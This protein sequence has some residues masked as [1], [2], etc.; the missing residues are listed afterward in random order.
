MN[1]LVTGAT[2]LL[3]D[4]LVDILSIEHKVY[5]LSRENI[6]K[7][8]VETILCDLIDFSLEKLPTEID[9]VF[10][11]AQ[12]RHFREFPQKSIDIFKI[13]IEAPLKIANWAIEND[14]KKFFYISSGGIYKNQL[15]TIDE[16]FNINANEKNGF[17]LDSKLSADLLLRN[18]H[19]FFESFAIIRP[20]FIYGPKQD[21][22]MFIPRLFDNILNGREIFLSGE[23]GIIIN[24]IYVDD[25]AIAIS[26]LLNLKGNHIINIA[27]NE[28]LSLKSLC[29]KIKKL[30]NKDVNFKNIEKNNPHLNADIKLMKELL[31]NPKISIDKGLINMW[32]KLKND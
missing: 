28:E 7:N 5:C 8:N 29:E 23:E 6:N 12:S 15:E 10:Y 14:V 2:G 1:I 17:Y 24:P 18:F 21:K 32:K 27:G 9:A 3:G 4:K 22:N 20:F 13:N 19:E 11:C 30:V 26:N 16:Y 25:A 31:Y